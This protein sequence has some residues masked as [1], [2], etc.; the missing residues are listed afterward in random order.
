MYVSLK[1]PR[2]DGERYLSPARA[3]AKDTKV[4]LAQ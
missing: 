1:Q 2:G 3:A 4:W